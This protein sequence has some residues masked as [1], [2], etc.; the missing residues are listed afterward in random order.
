[1]NSLRAHYCVTSRTYGNKQR[2]ISKRKLSREQAAELDGQLV[3]DQLLRAYLCA[4]CGSYHIAKQ[5]VVPG[6]GIGAS[7]RGGTNAMPDVRS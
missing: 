3:G 6:V 7:K 2:N 4:T 5:Y 1:M